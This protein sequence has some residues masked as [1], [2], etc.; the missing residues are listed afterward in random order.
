MLWGVTTLVFREWVLRVDLAFRERMVGLPTT[1]DD[2]EEQR[3]VLERAGR[4]LLA[5]SLVVFVL[6]AGLRIAGID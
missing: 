3:Q 4:A 1:A 5:V 6:G 2:V